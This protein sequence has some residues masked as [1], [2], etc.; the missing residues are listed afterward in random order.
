MR[1]VERLRKALILFC[2]ENFDGRDNPGFLQVPRQ[3]L[4]A[5]HRG[6]GQEG[7]CECHGRP[8]VYFAL[9]HQFSVAS[10]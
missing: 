5:F 6:A 8:F 1:D 2:R 10:G 3:A 4:L 9:R 7:F